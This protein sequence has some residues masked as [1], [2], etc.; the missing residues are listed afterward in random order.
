MKQATCT[1]APVG[2]TTSSMTDAL[3]RQ[4]SRREQHTNA[5]QAFPRGHAEVIKPC[6]GWDLG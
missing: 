3:A 1:Q 5:T 6:S 4:S 2:V